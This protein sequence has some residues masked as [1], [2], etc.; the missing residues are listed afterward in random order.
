MLSR[1]HFLLAASSSLLLGCNN[2]SGRLPPRPGTLAAQQADT[3]NPALSF[4]STDYE[5][6]YG[7]MPN[8]PYPIPAVDLTEIDP[9]YYR[10]EVDFDTG[11]PAGSILVDTPNRFLYFTKPDGKAIRY[12]VGI[13]RAGFAWGGT[14]RIGAKREWP[15]WFPPAEMRERQPELEKYAGGMEPGLKNPLG[16]RALY[17]YEGQKDTLYRVHGTPQA[18]SIGKAVSSGCVRMLQ[19]DII[20]LYQRVPMNAKIEVAQA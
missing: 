8:E 15:K 3:P 12:G 2:S 10:Q 19:Q 6:I 1:R 13:G 11:E 20:D 14:A 18:W 7:A 5:R 4:Q 16:A 9:I 17:I